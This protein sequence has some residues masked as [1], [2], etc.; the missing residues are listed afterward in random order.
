MAMLGFEQI[1]R[2]GVLALAIGLVATST[3]A[4]Q[5]GCESDPSRLVILDGSR[6][7]QNISTQHVIEQEGTIYNYL[8][9]ALAKNKIGGCEVELRNY[10]GHLTGDTLRVK[11]GGT[12]RVWIQNDLEFEE[13]NHG[14]HAREGDNPNDP[15]NFNTT[16]FH[17]HGLHV[18]PSGIADNVL[19]MMPP[20]PTGYPVVIRVPDDHPAGTFWYHAHIHGSTAMQVSSGMSGALIVEGGLDDQPAI[21]VAA[22]QEKIMLFQQIAYDDNG[23][24]NDYSTL[25]GTWWA[26]SNRRTTINGQIAPVIRMRPGEIQR[27]RMIH[28]GIKETIQVNLEGH[29]L[30]E[31]AVDG[32]ATGRCD[33]WSHVTLYPGYRSDVLVKASLTKGTYFLVDAETEPDISL[34]QVREPREVLAKVI[35]EGAPKEMALPCGPGQLSEYKAMKDITEAE[36]A[37]IP[38]VDEQHVSFSFV[39][40]YGAVDGKPYDPDAPPRSLRLGATARWFLKTGNHPFHIHVNAFQTT[41]IGP[42]GDAQTLWRDTYYTAKPGEE[43]PVLTRYEEF[44]GAFVLHCHILDHEDVGMMQKV[45]IVQ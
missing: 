34:L 20:G 33:T 22:D 15:H 27:W 1:V 10:N 39:G 18:S 12:L 36:A 13:D 16:N 31:I 38:E 23:V 5:P 40:S 24:I 14:T 43:V 2:G 29:E 32:L 3:E 44:E 21:K 41:R 6:E 17:S 11:P 42:D 37:A 9:V 4:A 8:R 26:D 30:H 7:F 35:V 25:R 19:R 45:E 28:G